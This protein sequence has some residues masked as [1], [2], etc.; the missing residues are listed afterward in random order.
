[1]EI[2]LFRIVQECLTNIH[3]HSGSSTARIQVTLADKAVALEVS[4][5]GKGMP[6][7]PS[8]G[9]GDQ[10]TKV[11]LGVGIPGMRERVKQLRGRF[12]M[13]SGKAGTTVTA[14]L[15]LQ[16]ADGKSEP[17]PQAEQKGA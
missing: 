1:V 11:R 3:Q 10:A 17:P 7:A 4:D 8:K 13:Q 2:T 6:A 15:P 14:V 9:K 12:E 16:L 5:D